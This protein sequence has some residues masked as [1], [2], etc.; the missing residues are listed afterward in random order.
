LPFVRPVIVAL[1]W[2]PATVRLKPPTFDVTV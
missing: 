2:V 1:S